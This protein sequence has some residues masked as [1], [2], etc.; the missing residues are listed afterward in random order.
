MNIL[1][2]NTTPSFEIVPRIAMLEATPY[3]VELI[4]QFS[5]S[6][7]TITA[8]AT[9]LPNENY[10]LTLSEFPEGKTYDKFSFKI[11]NI[12]LG[13]LMIVSELEDIQ[14]YESKT[15]QKYYH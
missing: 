9:R 1:K 8:T 4:N 11:T 12:C 5:Q 7:Q 10:L 3:D 2:K 13:T 14:N 6:K 15:N